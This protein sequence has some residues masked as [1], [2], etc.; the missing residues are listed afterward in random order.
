MTAA[1]TLARLRAAGVADIDDIDG[2]VTAAAAAVGCRT[3]T[4][5][6]REVTLGPRPDAPT[7]ASLGA[8][9]FTP[10]GGI[11]VAL[12]LCLGV[13]WVADAPHPYP[14]RV[15]TIGELEAAA[16]KIGMTDGF[17]NIKGHLNSI[18]AAAR[19]VDPVD[20][21]GIPLPAA[22]G[23]VRRNALRYRLGPAVAG[24][25]VDMTATLAY[26]RD[27]FPDPPEESR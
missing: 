9:G 18:L 12:G 17:R 13:A 4:C 10:T 14:G 19:L 25:P 16:R 5:Q 7:A 3:V 2:A 24:W 11:L 21:N 26:H 1:L 20:G 23:P 22:T 6:N 15:F 27:A 8:P